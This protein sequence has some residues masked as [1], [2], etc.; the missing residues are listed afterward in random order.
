MNIL[1][2]LSNTMQSDKNLRNDNI[3][4]STIHLDL[5]CITTIIKYY[6][7]KWP[8]GFHEIAGIEEQDEWTSIT[9]KVIILLTYIIDRYHSSLHSWILL[10]KI[11]L[12]L[13]KMDDARNVMSK[14]LTLHPRSGLAHLYH[15]QIQLGTGDVT[16][17]H[18]IL[19]R[20]ISEDFGLK[21]HPLYYFVK[22]SLSL[23][24]V[25]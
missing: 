11:Y 8:M 25:R 12:Q 6:L 15:A 5:E 10:A 18:Q 23:K 4:D 20:T 3:F 24:E 2:D 16:G 21:T 22:G 17:V 1:K 14:C 9:E 13:N 7:V 19:E